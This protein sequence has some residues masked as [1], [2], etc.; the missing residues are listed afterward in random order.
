MEASKV[1]T[2]ARFQV[3][4]F[5]LTASEIDSLVHTLCMCLT[6]KQHYAMKS[7]LKGGGKA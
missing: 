1:V 2:K 7:R 5:Y 6:T 4:I 3:V